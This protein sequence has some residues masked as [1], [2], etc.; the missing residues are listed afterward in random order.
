MEF[1]RVDS[2]EVFFEIY[3]EEKI[4]LDSMLVAEYILKNRND[5][6]TALRK[7]AK[8][9]GVTPN[10]VRANVTTNLGL[11]SADWHDIRDGS[12]KAKAKIANKLIERYQGKRELILRRFNLS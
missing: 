8:S 6:S 1:K 3:E 12:E 2:S 9:R 7:I 10:S 11:S 4:Y 5:F